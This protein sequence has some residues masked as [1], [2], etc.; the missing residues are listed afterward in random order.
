[1]ST[2]NISIVDLRERILTGEL[3][4][5]LV[6][7]EALVVGYDPR[8]TSGIYDLIMEIDSFS[9]GAPS[10][11]D[12]AEV[13]DY[14]NKFHKFQ[15]VSLSDS[16]NASKT[17]AEYLHPKRKQI[18]ISDTSSSDPNKDP[19]TAEEVQLFREKFNEAY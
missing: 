18:D 4:D 8:K 17:L 15:E 2:D 12:W 13:V 5:P 16:F 9:G 3:K 19:L 14:A 6:F 7:L 11:Q 1:M 10:K